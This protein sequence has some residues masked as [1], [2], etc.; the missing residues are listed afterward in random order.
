MSPRSLARRALLLVALLLP[1]ASSAAAAPRYATAYFAGG[2]FWGVEW[3]FEHVRGV[4]TVVAGY[5]GGAVAAPS[6]EQVN[7]GRTGHAEAVKVTYDPS[8]VTYRQ[9]LEVF[10]RVAHDPTT[11]D[12][13][14]PDSGPDY[15]AIV[16]VG[17][18]A[19][20]K[21]VDDYVAELTSQKVF[22]APIVTEVRNVQPFYVAE[23]YHQHY[24]ELNPDAMYIVINDAPKLK[25]LKAMFPGLYRAGVTP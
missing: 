8:V 14:G 18:P 17:N 20:R 16:W 11:R 7:S 24:A 15:R 9:L 21:L 2:C 23:D 5:S 3:V 13:Q 6:Y 22:R 25:H 10:Y 4:Q 19:E 1:R 12:R